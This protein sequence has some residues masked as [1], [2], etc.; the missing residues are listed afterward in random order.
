MIT[1]M[2]H[3]IPLM[4]TPC[5]AAT[6]YLD[7]RLAAV[8]D[9]LGRVR[10]SLLRRR[11]LG[12]VHSFLA[13]LSAISAPD[14]RSMKRAFDRYSLWSFAAF[15]VLIGATGTTLMIFRLSLL[16]LAAVVV[17]WC[18]I[19]SLADRAAAGTIFRKYPV[20]ND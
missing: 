10:F 17:V 5:S 16:Y 14:R 20:G 7:R 4:P 1:G 19:Q 9:R 18:L 13:R 8:A 3:S 2:L 6:S 11:R 15:V 12:R